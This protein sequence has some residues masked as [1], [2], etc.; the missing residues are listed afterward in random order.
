[1][2]GF[3]DGFG[4]RITSSGGGAALV[5]A[6]GAGELEVVPEA[7]GG[8][9]W[10]RPTVPL[11]MTDAAIRT[12]QGRDFIGVLVITVLRPLQDYELSDRF[13]QP[14]FTCSWRDLEW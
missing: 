8:A 3:G 2:R 14:G 9:S 12:T 4:V 11:T 7:A 1:M 6:A 13:P 5:A 10:A